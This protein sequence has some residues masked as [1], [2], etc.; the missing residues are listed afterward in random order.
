MN[1]EQMGK[2]ISEIRKAKKMTQKDLA[3][4]LHIT[5]KAVSKWERGLSFPDISLLSSI[6]KILD[7]STSELLNGERQATPVKESNLNI[8]H[9]L[10]YADESVTQKTMNIQNICAITFSVLLM[11]GIVV[12]AICDIAI[13]GQFTWSLYPIS[14]C[15]LAWLVLFPIIKYGEK[16]LRNSLLALSIFIIPY[17][18]VLHLLI[19]NNGYLL[20][21]GI[22]IAI[23]SII[24]SWIVYA[25]Y[26]L[27]RLR[28]SIVIAVSLLLLLP[29]NLIINFISYRML[30][31]PFM[32]IWDIL[33]YIIVL[34]LSTMLFAY[35]YRMQKKNA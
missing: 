6:A 17:L 7:V 11:I 22:P 20:S 12:C 5:D 21:M 14:S 35:D 32:D 27:T 9:V 1:N 3:D 13:T 33:G 30:S 10:A 15:A 24:Y 28:K 34:I 19:E 2:F 25:I 18:Y 23:A 31:Q 4:K 29:L 8:E 16:G 26:K